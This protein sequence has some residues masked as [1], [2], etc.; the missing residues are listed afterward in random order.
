MT[1]T[2]LTYLAAL[3]TIGVLDFLW[4]RVVARGLYEG[5]MAH[6][7]APQPN[8]WAAAAFYL[9]YPVG[10]VIFAAHPSQGDWVRA[11][12]IGAV[13]GLF[14]YGTYDLTNLAVIRDWPV[15]LTFIDIAWGALVSACG[16]AAGALAWRA[17]SPA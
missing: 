4:L 8:L 7:L 3:L 15:S 16:A 10:V 1:R 2:L 9:L 6:V 14:C 5:G 11:A 13:F 12:A 17:I